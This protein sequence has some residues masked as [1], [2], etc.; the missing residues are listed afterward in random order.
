MAKRGE[1]FAIFLAIIYLVNILK[2]STL[3]VLSVASED[4]DYSVIAICDH[5]TENIK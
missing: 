2:P 1:F 4:F 5:D 3:Y